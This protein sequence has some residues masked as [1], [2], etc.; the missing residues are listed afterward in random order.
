[1]LPTAALLA[2]PAEHRPR[3]NKYCPYSYSLNIV[4]YFVVVSTTNNSAP[5][6]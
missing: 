4:L 6:L 1:M 2:L 3:F 5:N